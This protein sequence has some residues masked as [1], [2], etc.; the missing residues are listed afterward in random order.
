MSS[1]D[2]QAIEREENLKSEGG[3]EGEGRITK[4]SSRNDLAWHSGWSDGEK[5]EQSLHNTQRT[6]AK[7]EVHRREST[8]KAQ[9]DTGEMTDDDG[10]SWMSWD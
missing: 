3:V 2:E 1:L 7:Q 5:S 4:A 9:E 6:K 10:G 8:A